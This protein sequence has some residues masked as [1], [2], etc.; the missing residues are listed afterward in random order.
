MARVRQPHAITLGS[1]ELVPGSLATVSV[2][3]VDGCIVQTADVQHDYIITMRR[4]SFYWPVGHHGCVS[5]PVMV[6]ILVCLLYPA[7]SLML[8]W[9]NWS[10]INESPYYRSPF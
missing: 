3:V 6:V 8:G 5:T 9:T 10:V 2:D 7:L 1:Y 4:Q